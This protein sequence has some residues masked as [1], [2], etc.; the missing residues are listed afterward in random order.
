VVDPDAETLAI[1]RRER[2]E[3]LERCWQRRLEHH[4][5]IANRTGHDLLGRRFWFAMLLVTPAALLIA[6][7][8]SWLG[9]VAAIAW[10][11]VAGGWLG[12]RTFESEKARYLRRK[13]DLEADAVASAPEKGS[14]LPGPPPSSV[15]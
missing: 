1:L 5:R 8:R 9:I 15:R 6:G 10:L 4:S 7:L 14:R 12:S 13:R 2:L 3:R 11:A